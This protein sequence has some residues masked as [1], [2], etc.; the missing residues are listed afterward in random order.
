MIY[1]AFAHKNTK[2]TQNPNSKLALS[3]MRSSS[4]NFFFPAPFTDGSR[5]AVPRNAQ[6][7]ITSLL[8]IK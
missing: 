1:V 8:F 6:L 2:C 7:T 4:L 3:E 5:N